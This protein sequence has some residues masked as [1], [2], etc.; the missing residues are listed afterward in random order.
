M[1]KCKQKKGRLCAYGK[2]CGHVCVY[3]NDTKIRLLSTENFN[4][5]LNQLQVSVEGKL[6]D[7][8]EELKS[9]DIRKL[10]DSEE[11]ENNQ[12]DR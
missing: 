9:D 4:G 1:V 3:L 2:I 5:E 7:T 6:M 10:I 12:F 8:I 11:E